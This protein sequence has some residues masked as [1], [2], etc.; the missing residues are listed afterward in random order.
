MKVG[1]MKGFLDRVLP[2]QTMRLLVVGVTLSLMPENYLL[3][4]DTKTI[5]VSGMKIP[6]VLD[7]EN[8]GPYNAIFDRMTHGFPFEVNLVIQPY[9]RAHLSFATRKSDCLYISTNR[10]DPYIQRGFEKNDFVISNTIRRINLRLYTQQGDVPISSKE[11]VADKTIA[12]DVTAGPLEALRAVLPFPHMKVL[13]VR[14]L[15]QGIALLQV[16]RVVAFAAFDV[17]VLMRRARGAIESNLDLVEGLFLWED[18]D[19]IT[20]WNDERTNKLINHINRQ[21]KVMKEAGWI[22]SQIDNGVVN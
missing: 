22:D 14:T 6:H 10:V 21:L 7:D 3:A 17:D 18:G 9:R 5:I 8:P 19:A 20:C 12:Y 4:V 15:D 16:Q 1:G 13:E 11:Q 2:T